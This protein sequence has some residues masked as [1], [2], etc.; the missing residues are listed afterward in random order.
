MKLLLAF[1]VSL[2]IVSATT[3][4]LVETG[5]Y[6]TTLGITENASNSSTT[7]VVISLRTPST[8]M[9]NSQA[10]TLGCIN[11]ANSTFALAADASSLDTLTVEWLCSGACTTI[12]TAYDTLNILVGT[13]TYTSSTGIFAHGTAFTAPSMT[14]TNTN[15]AG[16]LTAIHTYSG[17]TPANMAS[18]N[19][20]NQ[21]ET[22]YLRC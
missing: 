11:V 9:T 22:S 17:M 6:Y 14:P 18:L 19:L 7:D 8:I 1:V 10:T 5:G 20:P 12:D 3:T 16:T 21:T 13:S 2:A 4:T 15:N